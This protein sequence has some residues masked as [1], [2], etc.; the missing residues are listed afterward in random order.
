MNS[1]VVTGGME[2]SVAYD[3]MNIIHFIEEMQRNEALSYAL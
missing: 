2:S 1:M 3:I